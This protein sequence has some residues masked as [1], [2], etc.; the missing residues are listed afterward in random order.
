MIQEVRQ[1]LLLQRLRYGSAG[2]SHFDA[3]RWATE[4]SAR[5]LGRNDIGRIAVG[6]QADLALYRL[7]ELRFSGAGDP[8]AALLL[9]GSHRA[10]SVM[11][12]GNWR[13]RDHVLLDVDLETLVARHQ[14]AD[15]IKTKSGLGRLITLPKG[16]YCYGVFHGYDHCFG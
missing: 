15:R 6:M 7:D 5:C 9:C 1:A 2:I 16:F 8:L 12:A 11:V 13:V 4:G 10:H 3:Y 14:S